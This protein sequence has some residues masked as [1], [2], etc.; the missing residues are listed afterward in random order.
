MSTQPTVM[1]DRAEQI[2]HVAGQLPSRAALVTRLLARQLTGELSRTEAGV[3]STLSEGPRRITE[4]AELEGLAQPTM[5]ILVKQL[6]QRGLVRRS[7][8]EDDGRVVL[9]ELTDTGGATLEDVRGQAR[10]VLGAYM[11]DLPDQ[12]VEALAAATEALGQL[13]TLLQQRPN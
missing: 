3:L 6:E 5:T 11:A 2:D 4:L 7:R 9:V 12:Q 13:A 1:T 8:R 10:D